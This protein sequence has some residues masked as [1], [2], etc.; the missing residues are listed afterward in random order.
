MQ[1]ESKP[2]AILLYIKMW[3]FLHKR[4]CRIYIQSHLSLKSAVYTVIM[5]KYGIILAEVVDNIVEY[6]NNLMNISHDILFVANLNCYYMQFIGH[7]P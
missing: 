6:V 4:L 3:V 5:S 2:P 7:F 1:G